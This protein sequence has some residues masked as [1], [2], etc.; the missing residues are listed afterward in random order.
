MDYLQAIKRFDFDIY[1][2]KLTGFD[3]IE[4]IK[5]TEEAIKITESII[6]STKEKFYKDI[7]ELRYKYVFNLKALLC[8]LQDGNKYQG[9]KGEVFISFK[10][11]CEE[12][13]NKNQLNNSI[14]DLFD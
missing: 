3:L 4:I 10:P 11:I 9:I 5:K 13:V 14:L 8:L 2:S 12:L 1:L 7:I 6:I